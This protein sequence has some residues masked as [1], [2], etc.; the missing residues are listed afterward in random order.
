MRSLQLR[1]L[2][3]YPRFHD[4]VARDLGDD[5]AEVRRCTSVCACM[6]KGYASLL[7]PAMD[8]VESCP[9]R[10]VRILIIF[11]VLAMQVSTALTC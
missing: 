4:A 10:G 11:S 5:P 6:I 1:K 7:L 8:F 3:L 2:L 9:F